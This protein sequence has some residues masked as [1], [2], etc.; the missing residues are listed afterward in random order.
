PQKW[1]R[2]RPSRTRPALLAKMMDDPEEKERQE[3]DELFQGITLQLDGEGAGKGSSAAA[4]ESVEEVLLWF[5]QGMGGGETSP[6]SPP[7]AVPMPHAPK[8]VVAPLVSLRSGDAKASE[9]KPA[10][11]AKS[12]LAVLPPI[13]P[14]GDS[15]GSSTDATEKAHVTGSGA[16]SANGGTG[17]ASSGENASDVTE[18][19]TLDPASNFCE[20]DDLAA[21]ASQWAKP[22]TIVLG[23]AKPTAAARGSAAAAAAAESV[24]PPVPVRAVEVLVRPDVSW[25][26]IAETFETVMLSHGLVARAAG[27]GELV[28]EVPSASAAAGGGSSGSGG[29]GSGSRCVVSLRIGV[30][31]AKLRAVLVRFYR[32]GSLPAAAAAA[33]ASATAA[34]RGSLPGTDRRRGGS[35]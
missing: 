8:T 14:G 30:T 32:A 17:G 7:P 26:S 20:L 35:G 27:P 4:G 29:G 24:P 34:D 21:A 25:M 22:G 6:G 18:E 15:S 33:A 16:S 31:P 2:N 9:S 5:D 10:G 19:A 11:I 12:R 13:P 3:L 28:A 1:T 23:K